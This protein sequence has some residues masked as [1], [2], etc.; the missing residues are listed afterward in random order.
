M[1]THLGYFQINGTT[2]HFRIESSACIILS[3]YDLKYGKVD[4]QFVKCTLNRWV[5][6]N[7]CGHCYCF[8]VNHCLLVLFLRFS[9]CY[10]SFFFFFF[11]LHSSISW[12]AWN[13]KTNERHI[14]NQGYFFGLIKPIR[15]DNIKS[16]PGNLINIQINRMQ[17]YIKVIKEEKA[18]TNVMI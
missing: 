5:I 17:R 2:L 8:L 6:K 1:W 13:R 11:Y 4:D 14:F 3:I 18:I 9:F 7:D 10:I 15:C 12:V 16:R